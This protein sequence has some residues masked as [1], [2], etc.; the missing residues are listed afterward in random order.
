M[1]VRSQWVGHRMFEVCEMLLVLVRIHRV[2]LMGSQESSTV[3]I[4]LPPNSQ[5]VRTV[6]T[7]DCDADYAEYN[8]PAVP[9]MDINGTLSFGLLYGEF[10]QF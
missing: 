6:C 10:C 7:R 1:N 9:L 4:I 2:Y 5:Q 8:G 3:Y